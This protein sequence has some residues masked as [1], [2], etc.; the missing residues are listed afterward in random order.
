MLVSLQGAQRAIEER[1]P[2][3]IVVG[4]I[5]HDELRVSYADNAERAEK[6]ATEFT[7][8]LGYRDAQVHAPEGSIDLAAL[9]RER[10]EAKDAFTEATNVLRA[11]VLRALDDG[12]AE[13]EVARTAR[14]DRMTVR[15]WSGKG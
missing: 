12:R 6:I 14:V 15:K 2:R 3:W 5:R 11:A 1:G 9:G 10:A 13:A 4:T 7:T 8:E